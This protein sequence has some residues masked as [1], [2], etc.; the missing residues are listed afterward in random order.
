MTL[1]SDSNNSLSLIFYSSLFLIISELILLKISEQLFFLFSYLPLAFLCL[2]LRPKEI[3]Q[4]VSLVLIYLVFLRTFDISTELYLKNIVFLIFVF[5][6]SLTFTTLNHFRNDKEENFGK[7]F[8]NFIL[9][10]CFCLTSFIFFYYK[11]LDHTNMINNLAE[12]TKSLGRETSGREIFDLENT[13]SLIV[14]ILP[15][16]NFLFILII[17]MINF[18]LASIMCKYMKLKTTFDYNFISFIASKN[19][20]YLFLATLAIHFFNITSLKVLTLNILIFLCSAYIVEGYKK[21]QNFFNSFKISN[22]LK[23]LIIFLLFLFLGYVLLLIIFLVGFYA[24]IK[25]LIIKE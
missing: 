20:N 25:R 19:Y 17:F 18:R 21:L 22:L 15:S 10:L 3:I 5:F 12:L 23:F 2:I 11:N 16:I 1:R 13:A 9:I 14:D 4:T 7:V 24:N 8:S 6:I